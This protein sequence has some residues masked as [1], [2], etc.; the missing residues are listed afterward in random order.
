MRLW[1]IHPKYL[2]TKGVVA[3]WRE[4]LLAKHIIDGKTRAYAHHP[5]AKRF[6]NAKRSKD[7]INLYLYHIYKE[8]KKRGYSFKKEK[9]CSSAKTTIPITKEQLFF[10][11][12]HL[13]RKLKKR[14]PAKYKEMQ[15][16]KTPLLHPVFKITKK[17]VLL[18]H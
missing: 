15:M 11:W 12:N 16:I 3:V 4:A 2:D 1:S 6:M 17:K 10:E 5:Q 18:I 13:K 7:A 9:F 8:A 14:A